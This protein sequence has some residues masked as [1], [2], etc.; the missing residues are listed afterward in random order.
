MTNLTSLDIPGMGRGLGTVSSEEVGLQIVDVIALRPE[1]KLRFLGIRSARFE[2]VESRR[3][4]PGTD[5]ESVMSDDDFSLS[6]SSG[7]HAP[8]SD[9][10]VDDEDEILQSDIESDLES[11]ASRRVTPD[12]ASPRGNATEMAT[13]YQLR[14]IFAYDDKVAIF[15]AKPGRL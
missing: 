2:V 13:I 12:D 1:I 6:V 9:V 10:A 14:E 4:T 8:S 15:K 5:A 11:N 3:G 7:T